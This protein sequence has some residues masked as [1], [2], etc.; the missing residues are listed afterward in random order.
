ME[1]GGSGRD[2]A[3]D[4]AELPSRAR[5]SLGERATAGATPPPRPLKAPRPGAA[6]PY[7]PRGLPTED[8]ECSAIS[9]SR[10]SARVP[11]ISFFKFCK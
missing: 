7:L 5:G 10:V 3:R 4:V 8:P 11:A 1:D 2:V 9:V 6:G